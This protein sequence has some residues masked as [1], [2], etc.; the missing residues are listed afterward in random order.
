MKNGC[1]VDVKMDE[2]NRCK[3]DKEIG[4]TEMYKTLY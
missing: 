1:K 3:L 2:K 4:G